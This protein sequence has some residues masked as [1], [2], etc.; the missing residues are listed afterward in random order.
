MII[1]IDTRIRSKNKTGIGYMISNIFPRLIEIDVYNNYVLFGNSLGVNSSR[2]K[3]F[4]LSRFFQRLSYLLLN[5]LPFLNINFFVGKTDIFIFPDFV[6]YPSSAR[7]KILFVPDLSFIFYPQFIEKRNL[8]FI[9]KKIVRSI[10]KADKVITI[11][12]NAK[13]EIISHYKVDPG[14]VE[15][16]YLGCREDIKKIESGTILNN[17]KK[18]YKINKEYILYFGTLEPRKNINKLIEA[19][20]LIPK[21]IRE[22]YILVIAGGKGWYYDEIFKLVEQRGLSNDIIFTG[23]LPGEDV[24]PIYSAASLFVFPSFYEGFGLPILEAMNCGVPVVTSDTS[25]LPEIGGKAVLYFN[26]NDKN[27]MMEKIKEV[28]SSD[29]LRKRMIRDGHIRASLFSWDNAAKDVLKI[30]NSIK[31]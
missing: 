31:C 4:N 12:E 19:Y 15:V 14:K 26:P 7:K 5:K 8:D 22:N 11:S 10:N 16:V 21:K 30:I 3:F 24:A 1:G 13:K 9:N 2:A 27:E 17:I 6:V 29:D 25:S 23:Y 20:D 28:L 18:K